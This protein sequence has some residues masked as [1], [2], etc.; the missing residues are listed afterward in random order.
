MELT[1][2]RQEEIIRFT[3]EMVRCPGASGDEAL[4]AAG[5]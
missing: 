2:D 3:Q 1:Q 4:T 5:D